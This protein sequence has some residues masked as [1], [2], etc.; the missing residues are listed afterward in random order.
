MSKLRSIPT[1]VG[2]SAADLYLEKKLLEYKQELNLE[3][4]AI[5]YNFV[6]KPERE[7]AVMEI[8]FTPSERIASIRV[9][10]D[11]LLELSI[12][13][14][15]YCIIHELTHLVVDNLCREDVSEVEIE[16]AVDTLSILIHRGRKGL[17]LS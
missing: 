3:D 16:E 17:D 6:L 7:N 9:N 1:A 2:A 15:D 5:A 11:K 13:Q 14:V 4:W 8:H 12:P 10:A